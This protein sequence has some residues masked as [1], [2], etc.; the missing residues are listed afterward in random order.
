MKLQQDKEI[1][2]SLET[3]ISAEMVREGMS[4]SDI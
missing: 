4:G 3:A 2:N 1:K